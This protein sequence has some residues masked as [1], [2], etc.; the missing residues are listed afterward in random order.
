[1]KYPLK[2]IEYGLHVNEPYVEDYCKTSMFGNQLLLINVDFKGINDF[3]INE[4]ENEIVIRPYGS[5]IDYPLIKWDLGWILDSCL[6]KDGR[7]KTCFKIHLPPKQCGY[8]GKK[9]KEYE[10]PNY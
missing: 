4:D 3:R 5:K 10:T 2:T 9:I 7:L 1:M 6:E 8:C